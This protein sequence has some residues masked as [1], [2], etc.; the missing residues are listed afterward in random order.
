MPGPA[1]KLSTHSLFLAGERALLM[2]RFT[3]GWVEEH[4]VVELSVAVRGRNASRKGLI[5]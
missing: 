1:A 3:D 2:G 4:Y 5:G